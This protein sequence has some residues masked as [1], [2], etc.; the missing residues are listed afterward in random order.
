MMLDSRMYDIGQA[1]AEL[2]RGQQAHAEQ[3]DRLEHRLFGNGSPGVLD[4]IEHR[5]EALESQANLFTGAL[6]GIKVVWASVTGAIV[7]IITVLE[8]LIHGGQGK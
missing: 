5:V 6:R 1:L 2:K 7:V 3:M 8:Y 4:K